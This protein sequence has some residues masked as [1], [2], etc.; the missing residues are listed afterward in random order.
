MLI[1]PPELK[2]KPV[3][4]V[5]TKSGNLVVLTDN[6]REAVKDLRREKWTTVKNYKQ[7][8]SKKLVGGDAI[9]FPAGMV[10]ATH[11]RRLCKVIDDDRIILEQ[12]KE[13]LKIIY[14]DGKSTA[15]LLWQKEIKPIPESTIEPFIYQVN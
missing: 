1:R 15:R 5:R 6:L 2:I 8:D 13:A 3:K 11:I 12:T 14:N 10:Y 7:P 9:K 4:A